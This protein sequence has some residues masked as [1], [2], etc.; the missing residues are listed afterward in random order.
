MY[1]CVCVYLNSISLQNSSGTSQLGPVP[2]L[3]KFFV[4]SAVGLIA[5]ACRSAVFGLFSVSHRRRNTSFGTPSALCERWPLTISDRFWQANG[6][7]CKISLTHLH[8]TPLGRRT[9]DITPPPAFCDIYGLQQRWD[10]LLSLICMFCCVLRRIR[11]HWIFLLDLGKRLSI[12]KLNNNSVFRCSDV[13]TGQGFFLFT[14]CSIREIQ[15]RVTDYSLQL[16]H[17]QTTLLKN[18]SGY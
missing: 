6:P 13:F 5:G 4:L 17:W 1:K 10:H 11:P 8:T 12:N 14:L 15:N 7:T 2:R 9:L 3:S 16:N 18:K